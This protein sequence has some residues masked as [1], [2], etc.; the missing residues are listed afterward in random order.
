MAG[1]TGKGRQ[2]AGGGRGGERLTGGVQTQTSGGRERKQARFET[3]STGSSGRGPTKGGKERGWRIDNDAASIYTQS[4]PPDALSIIRSNIL[5]HTHGYVRII[6]SSASSEDP[7]PNIPF[8]C[9]IASSEPSSPCIRGPVHDAPFPPSLPLVLEKKRVNRPSRPL[10]NFP[11]TQLPSAPAA[12]APDR[13]ALLI[14]PNLLNKTSASSG[15]R[16]A[17]TTIFRS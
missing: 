6:T 7:P 12:V 17:P 8:F 15:V 5:T 11:G 9:L 13:D 2:E 16:P 4:S 1:K 10:S 3:A 14:Y